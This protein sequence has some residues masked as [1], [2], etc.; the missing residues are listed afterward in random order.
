MKTNPGTPQRDQRGT[1]A[2]TPSLWTLFKEEGA[3][4]PGDTATLKLLEQ[5]TKYC[6]SYLLVLEVIL[7]LKS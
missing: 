4:L 2:T 3:T 5:K 7:S 1:P 6:S